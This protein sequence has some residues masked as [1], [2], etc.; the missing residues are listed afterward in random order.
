MPRGN[1]K[2]QTDMPELNTDEIRN[3]A[4]EQAK[5]ESQRKNIEGA[6]LGDALGDE[7]T[8]QPVPHAHFAC[9]VKEEKQAEHE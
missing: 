9:D 2:A 5:R 3:D 6:C 4:D 1:G 8:R 7:M